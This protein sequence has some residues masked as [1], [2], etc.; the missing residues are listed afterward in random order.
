MEQSKK[1]T[2]GNIL[3]TLMRFAIP[4]FL[5]LL[6]QALYGGVDLL[7]VGQFATTADVSGVSTGSTL[8]NTLTMVIT[9]LAMGITILVGE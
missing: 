4:I 1:L 5:S 6:L 7:V 2:E 3:G 9:G 8:L